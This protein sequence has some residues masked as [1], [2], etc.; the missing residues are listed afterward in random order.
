MKEGPSCPDLTVVYIQ[1]GAEV[2]L[3]ALLAFHVHIVC[4][5]STEVALIQ[6]C[7]RS[8]PRPGARHDSATKT[9]R[10]V[11]TNNVYI[12]CDVHCTARTV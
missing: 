8:V 10:S 9:A 6:G 12:V 5:Y 7:W 1:N 2:G 11:Y 4:V 3:Y